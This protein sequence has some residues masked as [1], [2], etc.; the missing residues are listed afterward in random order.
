MKRLALAAVI[1]GLLVAVV[2]WAGGGSEEQA[3]SEVVRGDLVIGIEVSG[4]LRA[5]YSD[6]LGP[7]P[8]PG[9]ASYKIAS[10]MPEGR[11]VKAGM[12]VLRFDTSDLERRLLEKMAEKESADKELEKLGTTLASE[13]RASELRLAEARARLRREDLKIDVPEDLVQA[14]QLAT[15]RLD[16]ELAADEV[17]HLEQRLELMGRQSRAQLASWRERSARAAGRVEEIRQQIERMTVRAPRDGTLLHRADHRGDKKRV[18]DSAWQRDKVVEIPDLERMMAEGQ[19]EEADAG[20]LALGQAVTLRLDAH[21][22]EVYSGKVVSLGDS[23]RRRS[24][25][26][27]LKVVAVEIELTNTDVERMRPG[28]RFQ[29]AIEIERVPDIL[30]AEVAAVGE[31]LDGPVARRKSLWG[32]ETV[33]VETG[34]SNRQQVEVLAGLSAGDRLRTGGGRP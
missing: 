16:R 19:V 5:A 33:R 1:V 22:D 24:R 27:P 30:L 25:F 21:P 10:L 6:L 26:N 23:V 8:M 34:R 14:N 11:A 9:V 29:G 20:L 28:M 17:A 18:G 32:E 12:P 4:E 2:S 3:W 13:R 7:P 31:G 15:T